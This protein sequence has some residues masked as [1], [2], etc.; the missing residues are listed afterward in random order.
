LLL[1]F[2]FCHFCRLTVDVNF[3]ASFCNILLHLLEAFSSGLATLLPLFWASLIPLA[4]LSLHQ[5][6]L[7]NPLGCSLSPCIHSPPWKEYLLFLSSAI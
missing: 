7:I 4:A 6:Y 1:T 5:P 2:V 3:P